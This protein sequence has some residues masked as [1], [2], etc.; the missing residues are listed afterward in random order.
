MLIAQLPPDS[1]AATASQFMPSAEAVPVPMVR[2]AMTAAPPMAAMPRERASVLR[3]LFN[4]FFPFAAHAPTTGPSFPTVQS[5][6]DIRNSG[7]AVSVGHDSGGRHHRG[8]TSPGD[9]QKDP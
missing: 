3:T 6:T 8:I 9:P 1:H 4:G 2:G 7:R 5:F